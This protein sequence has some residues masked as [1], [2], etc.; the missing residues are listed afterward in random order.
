[1]RLILIFLLIVMVPLNVRASDSI[2]RL[3]DKNDASLAYMVR[4]ADKKGSY[5]WYIAHIRCN[6]RLVGRQ[7]TIKCPNQDTIVAEDDAGDVALKVDGETVGTYAKGSVMYG[8]YN[9]IISHA[10]GNGKTSKSV[11]E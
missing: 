10:Y 11:K 8:M 1:M 6:A 2:Y 5:Y 9:A 4:P 3:E 7:V